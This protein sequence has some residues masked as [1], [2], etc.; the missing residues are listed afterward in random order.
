MTE[1]YV[2]KKE[3]QKNKAYKL[4]PL[5]HKCIDASVVFCSITWCRPYSPVVSPR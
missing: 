2:K 3:K 1:S 4:P 5:S